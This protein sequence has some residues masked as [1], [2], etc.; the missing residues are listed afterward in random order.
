[1]AGARSGRHDGDACANGITVLQRTTDTGTA[2]NP[3][4]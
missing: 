3:P 2:D 1:M 4:P